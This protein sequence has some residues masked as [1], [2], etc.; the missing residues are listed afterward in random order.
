M[1]ALL[2][3]RDQVLQDIMPLLRN[4]QSMSAWRGGGGGGGGM[5]AVLATLADYFADLQHE[6]L[7]PSVRALAAAL[8]KALLRGYIEAVLMGFR[9]CAAV[10]KSNMAIESHRR[11]LAGGESFLRVHWVAV[12][13]TLRARR[14]NRRRWQRQRRRR[15]ARPRGHAADDVVLVLVLVVGPG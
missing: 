10:V 8:L 12:P 9:H 3:I 4:A 7:P 13:E 6:L 5:V 2:W 14:V 11:E 15:G 1:L